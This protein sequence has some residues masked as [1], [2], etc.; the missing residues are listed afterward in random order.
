ML[1]I[2]YYGCFRLFETTIKNYGVLHLNST[3]LNRIQV[4]TLTCCN[5]QVKTAL[6]HYDVD[7][8]HRQS[9]CNKRNVQW[10]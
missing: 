4:T 3:E 9:C 6:L 10:E 7:Y 8:C 1:Y 2:N 5:I